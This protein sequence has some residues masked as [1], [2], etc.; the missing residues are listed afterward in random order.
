[1]ALVTT[2]NGKRVH[3]DK[4]MQ[5]VIDTR[6]TFTDGS[7]CDVSSGAVHNV[8]SGYVNIGGSDS[9]SDAEKITVGPTRVAASALELNQ[10]NADVQVDVHDASDM[11]YTI[12]G[13]ADLVNTIRANVR[14]GDTLVIESDDPGSSHSGST[15]IQSGSGR[16]VISGLR[17]GGVVIGGSSVMSNVFGRGNMTTVIMGDGNDESEV[18]I[19]VKVPRTT[20][21]KSNHVSGNVVI[22]DTDGLLVASVQANMVRAGRVSAAQLS[23]QGSGDIYVKEVNGSAVAQVQGSGDIEIESGNMPSLSATIQG[24]GDIEIGGSA[25]TAN[26]TVQGSGDINV[27]HVQQRPMESVMGSGDINVR[28]VG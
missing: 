7:W 1:M 5:S 27:A 3:S 18:K 14:G 12:T 9:G 24:S 20:P 28:R 2:I 25:T 22:D 19:T 10:I 6:V 8:G 21:I 4:Q 15:I 13:P 26:L 16:T 23:V 17:G 11:E